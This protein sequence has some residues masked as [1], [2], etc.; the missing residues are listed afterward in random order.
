[1]VYHDV[2][3]VWYARHVG[4]E[5]HTC[6]DI[7]QRVRVQ[8]LFVCLFVYRPHPQLEADGQFPFFLSWVL[9]TQ[10][11]HWAKWMARTGLTT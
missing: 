10:P 9:K 1:M 5:N 6:S 2:F 11:N 4:G 8:N 7:S 3:L